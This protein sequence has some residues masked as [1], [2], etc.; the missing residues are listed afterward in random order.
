MGALEILDVARVNEP[1]P[2]SATRIRIAKIVHYGNNV[3]PER[4]NF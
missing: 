2:V 4:Q 1:A 3:E